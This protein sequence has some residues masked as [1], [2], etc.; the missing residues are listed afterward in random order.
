MSEISRTYPKSL[1]LSNH[2]SDHSQDSGA[3]CHVCNTPLTWEEYFN[4]GENFAKG[5]R[6]N[7]S[8]GS[9]LNYGNT[10]PNLDTNII[11]KANDTSIYETTWY[12]ATQR[13]NWGK[14]IQGKNILVH[15][16]D[17]ATALAQAD[18]IHNESLSS[19]PVY[20]YSFQIVASKINR[21]LIKDEDHWM[22]ELAPGMEI[23]T[24]RDTVIRHNDKYSGY[25]YHNVFEN[26]GNLSIITEPGNIKFDTIEKVKLRRK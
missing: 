14:T 15:I 1:W 12:H 17:E 9:T 21:E 4:I 2:I 26:P 5:H 24:A 13:T 18:I 23:V 22:T 10:R 25:A 3:Y 20:L 11:Q 8:C 6:L 16:G 7:H 19:S